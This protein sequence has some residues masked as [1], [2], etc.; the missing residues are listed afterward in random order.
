M[1]GCLKVAAL[2]VGVPI[3][4]LFLIAVFTDAPERSPAMQVALDKNLDEQIKA[5]CVR[6]TLGVG[7]VDRDE[8]EN[9]AK[10]GN[11]IAAGAAG[12]VLA[13]CQPLWDARERLLAAELFGERQ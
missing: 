8:L 7:N 2:I 11:T 3:A 6:K 4:L 10:Y 12:E 5:G 9:M 13:K 1:K